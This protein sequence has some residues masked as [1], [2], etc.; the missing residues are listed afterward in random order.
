MRF[1]DEMAR[2]WDEISPCDDAKVVKLL[3]L[4]QLH[5]GAA[6]LDVG[7][8]TGV[9]LPFIRERVGGSV[10][11]VAVDSSTKMLQE[12][13]RQYAHLGVH[14]VDADVERDKLAGRFDAVLLY[15]VFPHFRYPEDTI[16]RLVTDNLRCGGRLLIAH[17]QS[18]QSLNEMHHRLSGEVFFRDLLP[19]EEQVARF[20]RIGL[21]VS[22]FDETDEYYYILVQ[23][24]GCRLSRSITESFVKEWG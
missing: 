11:I 4:L 24:V 21:T 1:F 13:E 3:S 20:T 15:Q 16:A 5:E 7:T 10:P 23:Q 12:A 8:G 2:C 14:F 18:R 22:S 9:M 17:A 19:V 6:L